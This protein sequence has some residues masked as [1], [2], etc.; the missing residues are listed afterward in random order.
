MKYINFIFSIIL[1][2]SLFCNSN[3]E[4]VFNNIYQTNFWKNDESVSGPGSTLK[5]TKEIRRHLPKL[6]KDFNIKSILD[7]PCGD[8]NWM[9]HLISKLNLDR[10]IGGDI[11]SKIIEVNNVKFGR[12]IINFVQLNMITDSLPKVDVILC[13]DAL[14]HLTY[15]DIIETIKNFK[16]SN[17]KYILI[18]TYSK[19]RKFRDIKTGEWR[20]INFN[21]PPFNFPKAKFQILE[22][23]YKPLNDKYL[24]LWALQDLNI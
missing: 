16:K 19:N 8:F 5:L 7:V 18:T 6:F 2:Q 10:Y 14:V 11:V 13:R 1:I 17:S 3:V 4:S 21:L 12:E 22:K 24:A 20:A 15:N 23:H 9:Q